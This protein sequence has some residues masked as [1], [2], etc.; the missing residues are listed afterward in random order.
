MD[1]NGTNDVETGK[2]NFSLD[3]DI[4]GL[5]SV[6]NLKLRN[7][8]NILLSY[9]N[10][11]SIR[12]KFSDFQTFIDKTF[13]IITIAESKLDESFPSADFNLQGYQFPPFRLDCTSNSGGL[14][15]FVKSDIPARHLTKFKLDP[16]LHILPVELRLRKEKLLVFNIYRPDR[17][18]IELFFDTLSNAIHFY[19]VDYN[20]IIVLG[21]FNLEPT[22]PKMTR[23]LEL[24]DMSNVIKTK[25]C[26]KIEKGTC[27]DLILT[28]SK[29]SI[30][31][32]GTV[33]TGLSDFHRLVYT[34]LKTK[35][36]KLSPK[37]IKY[38]EYKNLNEEQFLYQ[39]ILLKTTRILRT[40]LII[41]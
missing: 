34:M 35:Y 39:L 31:N 13:D 23:F 3:S 12:N 14:L 21:D 1:Q 8:N 24:N 32:S 2:L 41:L 17:I 15:T 16:A 37:I 30:K 25:T 33:E 19:E 9:L 20:N 18:N 10:I 36:T 7:P 22:D 6:Q 28:N 5:K 38:R 40:F 29:N 11:N 4:N 27:I 26:F